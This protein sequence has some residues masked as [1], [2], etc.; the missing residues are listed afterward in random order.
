MIQLAHGGSQGIFYDL[1]LTERL[2]LKY[3]VRPWTQ[4]ILMLFL[5]TR[6]NFLPRLCWSLSVTWLCESAILADS[7]VCWMSWF[8]R[9]PLYSRTAAAPTVAS[10]R[11]RVPPTGLQGRGGTTRRC[12][13]QLTNAALEAGLTKKV[14]SLYSQKAEETAKRIP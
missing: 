4:R 11:R 6:P 3:A 8:Q 1:C 12:L 10:P 7:E 13:P 5:V 14:F 9:R 2:S